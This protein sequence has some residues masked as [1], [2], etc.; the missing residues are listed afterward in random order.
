MGER[1]I[2]GASRQRTTALWCSHASDGTPAFTAARQQA[3]CMVPCTPL[4][5]ARG[6]EIQVRAP[7]K[8][9]VRRYILLRPIDP[10]SHLE[11]PLICSHHCFCLEFHLLNSRQKHQVR[12][13][14]AERC[15]TVRGSSGH[16][17]RK[18]VPRLS[19]A[20]PM[21]P[22]LPPRE[23]VFQGCQGNAPDAGVAGGG[24][25]H[26]SANSLRFLINCVAAG[27]SHLP[28]TTPCDVTH[29]LRHKSG[30]NEKPKLDLAWATE[31]RPPAGVLRSAPNLPE[32]PPTSRP[33]QGETLSSH[34]LA[35]HRPPPRSGSPVSDS[36][37]PSTIVRGCMRWM[38]WDS[39]NPRSSATSDSR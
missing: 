16:D 9:P 18:P 10:A 32:A 38:T 12:R 20:G 4:A 5:D 15:T 36:P 35:E 6:S 7:A 23:A 33:A 17:T 11:F 19:M 8:L 1:G 28:R 39:A 34:T 22:R 25:A 30:G 29:R 31:K 13:S 21:P 3:V 2:T 26:C 14:F 27:S 37:P 24:E